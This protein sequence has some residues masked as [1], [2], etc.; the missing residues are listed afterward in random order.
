MRPYF[1]Y[2][3]LSVVFRSVKF[4]YQ[5]VSTMHSLTLHLHIVQKLQNKTVR[6][7]LSLKENK[8]LTYQRLEQVL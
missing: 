6:Q 8:T 5:F 2:E 7:E 4:S 3:S 1:I